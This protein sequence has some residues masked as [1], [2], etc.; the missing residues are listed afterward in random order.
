M[1]TYFKWKFWEEFLIPICM[2]GVLAVLYII[3]AIVTTVQYTKKTRLLKLCGY[4]CEEGTL[5]FRNKVESIWRRPD[6][7]M[8]FTDNEIVRM[9]YDE[10]KRKLD[11]DDK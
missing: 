1:D 11:A 6:K 3:N 2:L 9:K 5:P 4:K 10:L 7:A 8:M